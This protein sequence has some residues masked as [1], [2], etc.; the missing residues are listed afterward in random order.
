VL[1]LERTVRSRGSWSSP[2]P[3]AVEGLATTSLPY[4]ERRGLLEELCVEGP[5]VRLVATFEDGQLLFDVV[6]VRG[7]EGVVAKRLRD[8][9]RPGERLWQKTKNRATQQFAEERARATAPRRQRMPG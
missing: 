8:P 9:Y 7:L 5:Q 1:I 2:S 6:C 4:Q 3:V